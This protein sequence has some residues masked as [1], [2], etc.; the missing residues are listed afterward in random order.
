MKAHQHDKRC[1]LIKVK[2]YSY[3]YIY[4]HRYVERESDVKNGLENNMFLII[5]FY[6]KNLYLHFYMNSGRLHSKM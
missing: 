2:L 3:T 4:K 6:F 5:A 1:T